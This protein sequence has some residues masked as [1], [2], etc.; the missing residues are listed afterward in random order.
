[1]SIFFRKTKQKSFFGTEI[2]VFVNCLLK[3][4]T[5]GTAETGG[6]K[7]KRG[8]KAYANSPCQQQQQ[9][10][11]WHLSLRGMRVCF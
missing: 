8:K 3:N 2:I 11:L 6:V 5:R 9:G 10:I 4:E 1:M 7:S